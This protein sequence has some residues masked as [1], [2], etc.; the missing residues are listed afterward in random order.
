MR[1]DLSK[2]LILTIALSDFWAEDMTQEQANE[3]YEG[4][5]QN[6]IFDESG[7]IDLSCRVILLHGDEVGTE[8]FNMKGVILEADVVDRMPEHDDPEDERLTSHMQ[9][10]RGLI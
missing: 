8:L 10:V 6:L 3:Y 5:M 9:D 7:I 1:N 2:T 4:N